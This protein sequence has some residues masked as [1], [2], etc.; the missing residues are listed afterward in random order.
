MFDVHTTLQETRYYTF[1]D[2]YTFV[3]TSFPFD[4]FIK[5]G[6][7]ATNWYKCWLSEEC[8][9]IC[10]ELGFWHFY[11]KRNF[12]NTL[13]CFKIKTIEVWFRISHSYSFST[14]LRNLKK[15]AD[16]EGATNEKP[17]ASSNCLLQ[18]A[19]TSVKVSD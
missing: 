15:W 7:S 5:A 6:A 8:F 18:R 17:N 10:I 19:H 16:A 2:T 13:H 3:I 12:P 14:Q 1:K 9:G 4:T 11:G